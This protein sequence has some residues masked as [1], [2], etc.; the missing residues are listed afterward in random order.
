[1]TLAEFKKVLDSSGI[2]FKYHHWESPAPSLP[3][4][5]Y[6]CNGAE[7]F[8]A[9]GVVAEKVKNIIIELYAAKKDESLENKLETALTNA[10]IPFE[11]TGE[12]YINNEKMYQ[13]IYE[14]QI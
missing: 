1:M 9:D 14:I 8:K 2:K 6:L 13:T 10:G 7:T 3:Y 11:Q 5:V 12:V 4:G